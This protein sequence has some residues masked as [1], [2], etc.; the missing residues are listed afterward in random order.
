M[1]EYHV[2][3]PLEAP[4]SRSRST[5][6]G[7][8]IIEY[9]EGT[10]DKLGVNDRDWANDVVSVPEVVRELLRNQATIAACLASG[11]QRPIDWSPAASEA[12]GGAAWVRVPCDGE[13][14]SVRC[15]AAA[16]G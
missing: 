5:G 4:T 8:A 12:D 14:S 15:P 7:G 11:R 1:P 2:Y 13:V 10:L 3:A 16:S 9:S 6:T